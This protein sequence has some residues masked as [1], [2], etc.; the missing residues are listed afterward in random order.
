M[1]KELGVPD[2]VIEDQSKSTDSTFSHGDVTTLAAACKSVLGGT[3]TKESLSVDHDFR[4]I[5]PASSLLILKSEFFSEDD[6]Y[7][8]SGGKLNGL[9]NVCKDCDINKPTTN[10]TNMAHDEDHS[11]KRKR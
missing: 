11:K 1:W 8:K 3:V 2:D 7:V 5:T 9:T 6:H 10:Q 4:E